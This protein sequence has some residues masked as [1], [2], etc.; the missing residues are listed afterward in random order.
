MATTEASK[1]FIRGLPADA[2]PDDLEEHFSA[3]GPVREAFIVGQG[4]GF[5]EFASP[6]DAADAV[7]ELGGSML[8]G[9]KIAVELAVAKGQKPAGAAEPIAAGSSSSSSSS[10]APVPATTAPAPAAAAAAAPPPP[11]GAP[12]VSSKA[13]CTLVI[14]GVPPGTT[15]QQLYKRV[16]KTGT[17]EKLRYPLRAPDALEGDEAAAADAAAAE[18][19]A[20]INAAA[21]A[22]AGAGAGGAV[23]P[24]GLTHAA[25]RRCVGQV[26]FGSKQAAE[27]ACRKLDEHTFKGGHLRVRRLNHVVLS[28]QRRAQRCRV[29]VR[30]L[31][32]D[33]T[34]ERVEA[35]FAGLD[36]C[37]FVDSVTL[38]LR[39]RAAGAPA[40]RPRLCRGFCFV[41]FF[42]R[43]DATLAIAAAN[44]Q[45]L[46]GR[47]IAVDWAVARHDFQRTQRAQQPPAAEDQPAAEQPATGDA[48]NDT[49]AAAVDG[50]G[51]D[52]DDGGGGGDDGSSSDSGSSSGSDSESSDDGEDDDD[53]EEDE[54]GDAAD[55]A[56]EDGDDGDQNGDGAGAGAGA[57]LDPAARAAQLRA[58]LFVRNIPFGATRDDVFAVF[59]NTGPVKSVTLV[60]DAATD[61]PRGSAFVQYYSAEA[62]ARAYDTYRVRDGDDELSTPLELRGRELDLARAVDRAGATALNERR[63]AEAAK[64][65]KQRGGR[66]RVYLAREGT[67]EEHAP[68]AAR[69]PR[70]DM[71]KRARAERE[72]NT[73][74]S[75]PMFFVSPTRLSVRNLDVSPAMTEKRLRRLFRKAALDAQRA[76]LVALSEVEPA[77]RPEGAPPAAVPPPRV[78][79]AKIIRDAVKTDAAGL[80]ASKGYGFVEFA[81]H[82]HALGALRRL[83]NNPDPECACAARGGEAARAAPAQHRPRLIVEFAVE[84]AAKVRIR[85]KRLQLQQQRQRQRCRVEAAVLRAKAREAGGDAAGAGAGAGAGAAGGRKRKGARGGGGGKRR[86]KKGGGGRR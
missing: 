1:V 65:R 74:L 47:P 75:S 19:A 17:V 78:K 86:R 42:S 14:W 2:G 24:G 51:D 73:K 43:A 62:C 53:E 30:N 41:Q 76:G 60:V 63:R 57:A 35:F 9:R 39:E 79:Q 46:W 5:V 6:D 80:P 3:I 83:N 56:A 66:R 54:D 48:K 28:A 58:T 12:C 61:T 23:G 15:K 8:K 25:L 68:E 29:I 40:A 50:G 18:A 45:K 71:A 27:K 38:P 44:G 52:N 16:R 82:V 7:S 59:K 64:G 26:T 4:M 32:F 11:R 85:T 31:P 20:A 70:G 21:G 81:E 34:P 72:K 77:L 36:K 55:G 49:S 10:A 33:V 69:V 13:A 37:G 84:N 22:G 67:V